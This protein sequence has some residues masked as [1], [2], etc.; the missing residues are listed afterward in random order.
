MRLDRLAM[1]PVRVA[2]R[3]GRSMLSDEAERAID[4]MLAGPL[5]ETVA[6]SLAQNHVLER[7]AVELLET[8]EQDR[9]D[10]HRDGGV[11]SMLRSPALQQWIASDDAARLI[12]PLVDRV[13]RS[14]AVKE[15]IV[16][17]VGSP[18]L[19]H[20]L[21]KQTSGFAAE[22][23]TAARTRAE[24]TDD[25]V[26]TRIHT[27]LRLRRADVGR[28]R[29]AG[30]AT[31]GVA[32]VVDAILA[33]L[34]FLVGAASIA[35]VAS[36]VGSSMTG[37]ATRALGGGVWVVAAATYF[38][39]FWSSTGQT[40]GMRLMG[41]RVADSMGKP[42]S[43]LR[44]LLRFFGLLLAIVPLFAGFL[45]VFVDRRRRALQDFIAGTVVL[46]DGEDDIDAGDPLP[47]PDD[48]TGVTARA[49]RIAPA[50]ASR[51]RRANGGTLRSSWTDV[52]GVRMHA[53][54]GGSGPPVVLVHGLGVS[55]AYMLPLA[56]VLASSCTAIVP[57][58][59][60]Q[61]RSGQPRGP[62][63]IGEMAD[64]LG[65]WLETRNVEAP[66]IVAN[67]M[68]CQ[69]VTEL[70]VRRP[71]L[72]GPM[73]LVG[74]TVD[75]ARRAARHQLFG[76]L[77]DSVHEPFSLLALTARNNAANADIRP[78][79]TAARSALADRI[80]ERLPLIDEPTVIVYGDQ[81][82]FIS[83]QWAERAAALLPRGRLVVVPSQAHAVHYTR[84]DLVAGIVGE[85]L[86][87][88][89]EH[90][91]GERSRRLQHRNVPAPKAH[92]PSPRQEPLPILR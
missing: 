36:L 75:P 65:S 37:W 49:P 81:D 46:H 55:G 7:V 63:G 50:P 30:F 70:A 80:E 77:R 20:A 13:L 10:G 16:G 21:S 29:F 2:A 88:E 76:V 92:D 33:Q 47:P 58:L 68:G 22:V 79:L 87:E 71:G 32:L 25:S 42:P 60:G 14:P 3:S 23:A 67:S 48:P 85:L 31:R 78:L 64:A 5:P 59:P 66:L 83:R 89:Q 69:I 73:V 40:P 4:G 6:R 19:R 24:H 90:R 86:G 57:D 9:Q 28:P 54:G 84:P 38:A 35:V 61:G 74:P 56:R 15:T 43:L 39:A 41:L 27:G 62:F 1:R 12:E 18:E 44:S 51:D 53:V 11:E 26:E 17:V 8:L 82:R 52:D 45:P 91:V 34:A 72:V